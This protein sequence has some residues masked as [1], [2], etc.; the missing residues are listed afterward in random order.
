[1]A[2]TRVSEV[3]PDTRNVRSNMPTVRTRTRMLAA[4]IP[5]IKSGARIFVKTRYMLAP[6]IRAAFS[7]DGLICSMNGVIVMI[8]NGT[9]GTRFTRMTASTVRPRPKLYIT[10]ASGMP[11]VIG[12]MRMGSRNSSITSFLPGKL[13][14]ASTYDAGTPMM[15]EMMITENATSS[16][17]PMMC[18]RS[19]RSHDSWY[20][21]SVK[22]SG[23]QV[24]NQGLPSESTSTLSTMPNRKMKNAAMPNQTNQVPGDAARDF[25]PGASLPRLRFLTMLTTSV[26]GAACRVDVDRVELDISPSL[27]LNPYRG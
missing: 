9:E 17:T 26:G 21:P 22:F 2:T 8:T 18:V 27:P 15:T 6:H 14:R 25:S 12:G 24:L 13:L 10:V 4:R 1:M 16:V 11:K 3:G 5:G 20:Q 19:K 7:M 23:S